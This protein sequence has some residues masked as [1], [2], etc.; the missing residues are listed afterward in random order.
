MYRIILTD[1]STNESP[2]DILFHNMASADKNY[3]LNVFIGASNAYFKQNPSKNFQDLEKEL[4]KRDFNTHI[5]AVPVPSLP[6]KQIDNKSR[7]LHRD[8]TC[9]GTSA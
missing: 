9:E 3:D 2:N 5:I 8:A 4:R 1:P 6:P 7:R